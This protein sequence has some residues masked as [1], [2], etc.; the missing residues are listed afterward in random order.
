MQKYQVGRCVNSKPEPRI[1]GHASIRQNLAWK[2]VVALLLATVFPVA[3]LAAENQPASASP[4]RLPK[5]PA[6]A[7]AASTS[8]TVSLSTLFFDFGNNLVGY[9]LTQ[10]A[11]AVTNTG[12]ATLT[13]S[14]SL[15]GDPSYSIVASKSCG[16]TLAPGKTCDVVLQYLPAKPS[17]PG[18]QDTILKMNYANADPGDPST[19]LVTGIS[20]V[21]KKGTVSP[22]IN[23]QVA[24]YT[25]T[26]P[27]P[28]RMKVRFGTTTSY[29]LDT[30]YQSTD[31]NNG[32]VSVF[33]AGMKE[34]TTYHM[35][36]SVILGD[37]IFV[38]DPAGD[39]TFT[40]GSIR[41]APVNYR[42]HVTSTTYSGMTP[43]PGIEMTNPLNGLAAFDLEGN[44]IWTYYVPD[45]FEEDLAGFKMLPNGNILIV[46]G[47]PPGGT[48][49]INEIREIDLA[50]DT[51]REINIGD[52][53]AALQSAPSSCTECPSIAGNLST[54]HHDVTPLP[55]GHVLVLTDMLKNLPPSETGEPKAA[56]VTGDVVVDLD[57][58]WNPVWAWNEFN[59]LDTHRHPYEWPDWTHSNA[60]V[61]SPDDGDFLI[62]IRHQNW[63]IKVNYQNGSGDGSM[64]WK[65]GY[66]G[67]LT[68]KGGNDP[69]DWQYAQ[70]DPGYFSPNTSGVFELGL[71]D[72]G[73][74]RLYPTSNKTCT[75]QSLLPTSCLYST[76]PV[77]Q[78][79]EKAKTATL[80]FH[81]KLPHTPANQP[82]SSPTDL[83]SFFGGN[84]DEL[85][86]GN[87]EYD[88]CGLVIPPSSAGGTAGSASMVREVTQDA[89]D[90]TLVWSLELENE[91]F[92]R[93]FRVP[94]L[95]PGVQW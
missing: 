67:T 70:H 91:N 61:Y 75:P 69:Q 77:F 79:D 23:Q 46:L 13:L 4:P 57:E 29:G 17:Y 6:A 19:V 7:S 74:D 37:N 26:L 68:L 87:V 21:L 12:T 73:D 2:M 82:G 35:I 38:T 56:N 20:A 45:P 89:S 88:L 15:S 81:Q 44:Q 42:E 9:K 51:V 30:W 64:V 84:T 55:N 25:M 58:N 92:Y 71:M 76:I 62:S 49:P 28:G 14:P 11:V 43:Q 86:N 10:T 80:V 93:A 34:Q 27:F 72:N 32:Q 41:T 16:T 90:P 85:P 54:F 33:V 52:L 39:Q 36:A 60:V 65:L 1:A 3:L 59:H 53:N 94:S 47:P 83:Y 40:T 24:L 50:G 18:A 5:S 22:T 78:I 31:S 66:Q 48:S 63:V 8:T 95:Y